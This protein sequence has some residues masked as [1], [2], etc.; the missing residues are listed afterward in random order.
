MKLLIAIVVVYFLNSAI[1]VLSACSGTPRTY[2]G[3]PCAS[4]T[5][6][7]DGQMGACGYVIYCLYCIM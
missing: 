3:M 6:Y 4:T 5:R 7:W 2:N 1:P